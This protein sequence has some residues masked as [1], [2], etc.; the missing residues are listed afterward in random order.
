MRFKDLL[1]IA[2]ITQAEL[3]RRLGLTRQSVCRWGF[4][5]PKYAVEYLKLL[6]EYN[7]LI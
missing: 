6:I 2:D 4:D 3:G 1:I 5:P 7:K